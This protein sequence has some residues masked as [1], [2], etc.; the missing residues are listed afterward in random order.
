MPQQRVQSSEWDMQTL[1]AARE[2]T[3]ATLK[4]NASLR[5]PNIRPAP[6]T[7][8]V[9]HCTLLGKALLVAC[10][11]WARTSVP[12]AE[13]ADD[14]QHL[15]ADL[16]ALRKLVGDKQQGQAHSHLSAEPAGNKQGPTCCT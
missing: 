10:S 13:L 16:G 15:G 8:P 11:T 5:S 14:M 6:S 7:S 9:A 12:T 1:G 4:S 2:P 3:S